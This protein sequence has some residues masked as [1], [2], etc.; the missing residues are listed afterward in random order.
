MKRSRYDAVIVG[1]GP[2]GLAAAIEMA[3]DG[4]ST[5]LVEAEQ[6][7]GGA[8]RSAE[9]T[10]PGF[11]HDVGAAILPLA[12]GS[13]FFRRLPL[14]A[15]GLEWVYPPAAVAHPLDG[16]RSVV[17]Y[18]S[19]V[20][21]AAQ[22]GQDR[23]RYLR[24]VQ[25][26]V[27][28]W[29]KLAPTL[30]GPRRIPRHPL[31]IARFGLLGLWPAAQ[32]SR[33]VFRTEEARALF[34]GFAAHAVLPLS[35]L[36]TAGYGMMFAGTAHALGW[37][38]PRGG[39]QV[40]AH[41]LGCYF[42]SLGGEIVTGVRVACLR[43]LPPSPVVLLDLTPR[44]VERIAGD[45]LPSRR[46][47]AMRRYRYGPAVFKV[48]YALSAPLPWASPP[49]ASAG[50]VHIGGTLAEIAE[51]ELAVARQ[52]HSERPFV[53]LAQQSLFD[54]SRAPAGNHTAWAY[55]HVP[56]GSTVD[57]TAR[58]EAQIER[59]APGFRDLILA[60]RVHTSADL[61]RWDANLVGGDIAGGAQDLRQFLGRTVLRLSPYGTS[62]RGL[63]ICSSA[64][65]PGAGVHG[66][67]G[68]HAARSA[69]RQKLTI[70]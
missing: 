64:T 4:R 49:V 34:A 24:L 43:D 39:T 7:I 50:T 41:A 9:L 28:D 5:L 40:L 63:F 37:P 53:L 55:C 52:G 13:P 15:H 14:A 46:R 32:L 23:A 27:A 45:V 70:P 16:G 21:T 29:E 8:T 25:P 12:V 62:H 11:V 1:A 22:L 18:R 6:S 61:E 69:L 48:D 42:E 59:F 38:F 57:M 19:M 66:M 31:A 10:L 20:E 44:Q 26:L 56:H 68:Y 30:L 65:P 47:S 51:A 67:C 2:N 36:S 60:R 33:T 35:R 3:H 17:V 54:A 58:I